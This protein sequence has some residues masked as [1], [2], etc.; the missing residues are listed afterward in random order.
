VLTSFALLIQIQLMKG[1]NLIMTETPDASL[2]PNTPGMKCAPS[3]D[4]TQEDCIR[5]ATAFGG[6]LF[7]DKLALGYWR[8]VAFGC[9]ISTRGGR[10][11][12]NLNFRSVND[13]TYN[14]VCRALENEREVT[15]LPLGKDMTC[16]PEHD[17]PEDECVAA[18]LLVGGELRGGRLIVGD[19]PNT[20]FGCSIEASDN[21]IHFSTRIDGY[22][23]G[24]FQPVCIRGEDQATLSPS[25]KFSKCTPGHDFSKDECISAA[26]SV[27]GKLRN[28]K[29]IVGEWANTPYGCFV[30][31]SDMAIHFGK[32]VTGIN[33]GFFQSVCIGAMLGFS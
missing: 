6:T 32:N 22:N 3:Y 9:S 26:A 28:G 17:F 8:N 18:A 31:K 29:L 7:N 12:Y 11:F 13:G 33:D 24:Y 27:G 19:W 5:E 20:P 16:M 25:G 10:I 15:L 21:A 2:L 30:E 23:D 14:P 1:I 4:L